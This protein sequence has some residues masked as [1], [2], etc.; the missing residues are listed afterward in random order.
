MP[1][2]DIHL[3]VKSGGSA[4]VPQWRT[5]FAELAPQVRVHD[6]D[7][8][9]L[10]RGCIDFALVWEPEAGRLAR[11]PRL[12]AVLSSAAG[13]DHLLADPLLPAHLPIVRMVT[14]ET[15]TR[16]AEFCTMAALMLQKD[17]LRAIH[18]QRLRHWQEFSPPATA[19][20][21]TVGILGLG[22]LGLAAAAM[23]RAVGFTV[24]GWSQGRKH[25]DGVHSYA[26]PD[27][28]PALLRRSQILVC[29][30]PDTPGTHGILNAGLFGQLP[31][32]AH[33]INV[34]RG[35]QLHAGDLLAA[36]D[37]GQIGSAFLDVAD[38]EPLPA[39]SP[40]WWHPRIFISP[41][42]AASASRRA[43]AVQA[44]FSIA[45][46]Q[47]GEPLSHTYDRARG[48]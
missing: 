29:L 41:H 30:L 1:P 24:L 39:D 36:L 44:A 37:G 21:M 16:M 40:L 32:G 8:P 19:R 47:R 34:G 48:Y 18:Q 11:F 42:T 3:V 23:L 10:D 9:A 22:T 4:A 43:K 25:V 13:V 17:M 35:L 28:L 38:P 20:E 15:Q 45:Q 26:G 7:D 27:E 14:P 5:L 31:R 33:L 2:S 6:W 46:W 12:K